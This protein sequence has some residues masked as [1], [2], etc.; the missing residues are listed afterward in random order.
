MGIIGS[1]KINGASY[2][3]EQLA[4]LAVLKIDVLA[5]QSVSKSYYSALKATGHFAHSCFQEGSDQL[6]TALFSH[7]LLGEYYL[8]PPTLKR[9]PL[10]R[11]VALPTGMVAIGSICLAEV[12]DLNLA[13]LEQ[14]SGPVILAVSRIEAVFDSSKFGYRSAKGSLSE[15]LLGGTHLDGLCDSY[16]HYLRSQPLLRKSLS[17]GGDR[18]SAIPCAQIQSKSPYPMSEHLLVNKHLSVKWCR[19]KFLDACEVGVNN[20]LICLH[21]LSPQIAQLLAQRATQEEEES[22]A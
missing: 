14:L 4:L 21:T 5:L 9:H 12:D 17:S 15:W 22:E 10:I 18:I 2:R 16:A 7:Y 19:Y 13:A 20:S 11:Y 8:S 6:G 1:W 3:P